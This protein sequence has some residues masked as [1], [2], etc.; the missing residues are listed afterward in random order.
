MAPFVASLSDSTRAEFVE[1][2]V[3]AVRK[4]GQAVRPRVLVLSSRVPA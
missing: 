4:R 1:H 3:A 2:A